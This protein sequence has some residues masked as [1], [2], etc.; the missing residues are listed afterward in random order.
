VF[1]SA[2]RKSPR[3]TPWS[4]TVIMCTVFQILFLLL[5]RLGELTRRTF[6]RIDGASVPCR[7]VVSRKVNFRDERLDQIVVDDSGSIG[8]A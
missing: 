6:S 8:R 5:G 1:P 4:A 2:A 7:R 3:A